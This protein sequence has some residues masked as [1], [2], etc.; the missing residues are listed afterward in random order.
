MSLTLRPDLGLGVRG[1]HAGDPIS[2]RKP[3]AIGVDPV[4]CSPPRVPIA[5]LEAGRAVVLAETHS[6]PETAGDPEKR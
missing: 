5:H 4:S 1:E 3:A 2:I 6:T